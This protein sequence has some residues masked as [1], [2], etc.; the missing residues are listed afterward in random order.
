MTRLIPIAWVLAGCGGGASP[1]TPC[2]ALVVVPMGEVRLAV[3]AQ[4]VRDA[5]DPDEGTSHDAV[6]WRVED[7]DVATVSEA[8]EVLGRA[9]GTT[10]LVA[11]NGCGQEASQ[12]LRV[13]DRIFIE[14]AT[15]SLEVGQTAPLVA[16]GGDGTEVTSLATWTGTDGTVARVDGEGAVQAVGPGDARVRA[17][18]QGLSA[19]VGVEVAAVDRPDGTLA[20]TV[21]PWASSQGEYLQAGPDRPLPAPLGSCGQA[22]SNHLWLAAEVPVAPAGQRFGWAT[23][24]ARIVSPDPSPVLDRRSFVV[25]EDGVDGSLYAEGVEWRTPDYNPEAW[26][27]RTVEFVILPD[28]EDF[29][30]SAP[31]YIEVVDRFTDDNG[32]CNP[33]DCP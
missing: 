9:A 29:L 4:A 25:F 5:V 21:G 3:G 16:R 22:G 28:D 13:T 26:V 10:R 19:E 1:P 17:T 6:Q 24:R 30:P 27:G 15:L 33:G 11:F 12:P 2:P 7:E 14:P 20:W 18:W 8:G 23:V 32:C 31:A